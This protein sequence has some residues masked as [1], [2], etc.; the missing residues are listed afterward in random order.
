MVT[1]VGSSE[2]LKIGA[3][4]VAVEPLAGVPEGSKGRVTIV[5]GIT[6]LRYG[7]QFDNGLWV[8]SIDAAKV[9][10]EKDLETYKEQRAAAEARR[11]AEAERAA[12]A[13]EAGEA[14]ADGDGAG[15]AASLIPAHILERSR[16]ARAR[17]AGG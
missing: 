15:G 10:P 14:G 16:A 3:N 13:P 4:V 9:V 7:V 1:K 11:A 17:L 12:A 2:P 6:W 5:N 8:G